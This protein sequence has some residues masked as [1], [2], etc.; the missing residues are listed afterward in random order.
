MLDWLP[1]IFGG[2]G[3]SFFVATTTR[4]ISR[5]EK[6]QR[7]TDIALGNMATLHDKLGLHSKR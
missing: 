4:R 6:M 7:D 1:W 2:V 3:F 5:L